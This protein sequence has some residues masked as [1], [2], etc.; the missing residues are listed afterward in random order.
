MTFQE[1]GRPGY[2]Q[3]SAMPRVYALRTVVDSPTRRDLAEAIELLCA[4]GMPPHA[5]IT[6][7]Q[8]NNPPTRAYVVGQWSEAWDPQGFMDDIE[9]VQQEP[10]E[11]EPDGS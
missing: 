2:I 11:P 7:D 9:A 4:A 8:W 3:G 6:V 10:A 5:V 1:Q